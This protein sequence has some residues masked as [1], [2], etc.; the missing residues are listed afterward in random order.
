MRRLIGL[1]LIGLLVFA[2][3][4]VFAGETCES[5]PVA[6]QESEVDS[7]LDQIFGVAM[8]PAHIV[9]AVSYAPGE[10]YRRGKAYKGEYARHGFVR[11]HARWWDPFFYYHE[12]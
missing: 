4:P 6:T 9:M 2:A 1:L 12:H 8:I 5:L 7:A 10:G 11:H 3:S